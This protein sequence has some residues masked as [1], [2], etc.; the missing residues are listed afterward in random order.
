VDE[1]KQ[2]DRKSR[3]LFTMS[4]CIK[5]YTRN[6]MLIGYMLVGKGVEGA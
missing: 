3:K 5:D 2:I 6:P 4:Q 1:E